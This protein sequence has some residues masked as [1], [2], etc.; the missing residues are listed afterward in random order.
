MMDN[1]YE[2]GKNEKRMML[3]V[4]AAKSELRLL[5]PYNCFLDLVLID[6]NGMHPAGK[7]GKFYKSVKDGERMERYL[8]DLRGLSG[9]LRKRNPHYF[10]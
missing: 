9:H 6:E 2:P 3:E 1:L 8:K 4:L 7:F 10:R 5:D